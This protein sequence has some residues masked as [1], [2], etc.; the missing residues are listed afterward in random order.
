MKVTLLISTFFF[1]YSLV[2][3]PLLTAKEAVQMAVAKEFQVLIAQN[4]VEMAR[5]MS[6]PGM[7]GMLPELS[8]AAS[9]SLSSTTIDQTFANGLTVNQSG[10][11]SDNLAAQAIFRWTLFDGFQMFRRYA[12]GKTQENAAS[13]ALKVQVE[14]L[15]EEVYRLYFQISALEEQ[16]ALDSQMVV[17]WEEQIQF[18]KDKER[19]GAGVRQE[20]LQAQLDLN[21]TRSNLWQKKGAYARLQAQMNSRLQRNPETAF[22]TETA[23]SLP[24][25]PPLEG[26]KTSLSSHNTLIQQSE[27]GIRLARDQRKLSQGLSLPTLSFQ[28]MYGY[29]RTANTAGFALFN[30]SNGPQIGLVATQP[31]FMGWQHRTQ[32]KVRRLE[33]KNAAWQVQ[34]IQ[35]R[36]EGLL[37]GLWHEANSAYAQYALEAKNFALAEENLQLSEELFRLG[38]ISGLQFREA[39]KSLYEAGQR[40]VQSVLTAKER[41]MTLMRVAGQW[42]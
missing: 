29:N 5:L 6:H 12:I 30:L 3:Q 22:R 9:G 34:Q 23:T 17:I 35:W 7:A 32:V 28:A 37:V 24:A 25:L 21:A 31:L 38:S 19:L 26:L 27:I 2:A 36:E 15:M 33:E 10:V 4:E 8:L 11:R 13:L 42:N 20:V 40:K 16:L 41:H 1:G 39:Q 14:T 18:L